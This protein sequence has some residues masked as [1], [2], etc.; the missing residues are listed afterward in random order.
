M[1][2]KSNHRVRGAIAT[3]DC[4]PSART[5]HAALLQLGLHWY[6][7]SIL[8]SIT[9]PCR[10]AARAAHYSPVT[11]ADAAVDAPAP[12]P[13]SEVDCVDTTNQAGAASTVAADEAGGATGGAS[14]PGADATASS[15]VDAPPAAGAGGGEAPPG[16]AP[17]G[18]AGKPLLKWQLKEIEWTQPDRVAAVR[19]G[20]AAETRPARGLFRGRPVARD[21]RLLPDRLGAAAA[22]GGLGVARARRAGRDA[23]LRGDLPRLRLPGVGGRLLGRAAAAEDGG[24]GGGCRLAAAPYAHARAAAGELSPTSADFP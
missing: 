21:E 10:K 20:A 24:G 13:G 11:M 7:N 9:N 1:H 2:T 4:L 8:G 14:P 6:L 15:A 19:A 5:E 23:R 22:R 17:S 18:E 12:S 3:V 16:A